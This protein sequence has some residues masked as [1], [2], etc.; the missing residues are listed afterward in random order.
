MRLAPLQG[1]EQAVLQ[2]EVTASAVAPWAS[3]MFVMIA[4]EKQSL[5]QVTAKIQATALI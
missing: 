2:D 1:A 5:L 4:Y 3:A